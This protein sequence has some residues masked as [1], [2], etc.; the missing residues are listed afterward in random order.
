MTDEEFLELEEQARRAWDTTALPLDDPFLRRAIQS[1]HPSG[2]R[3]EKAIGELAGI[4]DGRELPF[5][6]RRVNDWVP[7]VRDAARGAVMHRVTP[8]YARHFANHLELVMRLRRAERADHTPL[9]E[10]I[11]QI[12]TRWLP[13][14]QLI[15][16]LDECRRWP[17]REAFRMLVAIDPRLGD[18]ASRSR[19]AVIRLWAVRMRPAICAELFDDPAAAVRAAALMAAGDRARLLSA[20]FDR[21]GT[22]RD[23]ARLRL[24]GENIDFAALYRDA[25]QDERYL[26]AISGLAETGERSDAELLA[27]FLAHERAAVRR[28][29]IR[30]VVSLAGD[31]YAERIAVLLADPSPSVSA[32]ARSSL[33]PH[34]RAIGGAKLW[35]LFERSSL[36]HVRR[37]A[38]LL[39]RALPKWDSVSLF[40]RA[41][42]DDD[43]EL[44]VLAREL[45]TH[46]SDRFNRGS[47]VPSGD[48]L[49]ALE[50]SLAGAKVDERVA[51]QIAFTLRTFR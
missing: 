12:L 14:D 49:D 42:C 51:R 37:N 18:T 20:L 29:A 10:T 38:L 30:G 33:A 31:A 26:A 11:A 36:S 32:Q 23:V 24:R 48:Q 15:S 9:L 7:E 5:L 40:L 8:A 46:W 43:D 47:A 27:P 22:V 45:V 35:D 13:R 50:T 19:D 17:R 2:Y 1:F 21:N 34:A 44:A 41:T 16:A 6:L 39:M 3:R 4:R 28:R 25:L